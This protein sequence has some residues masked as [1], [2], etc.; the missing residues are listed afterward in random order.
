MRC[1]R[2]NK[3]NSALLERPITH[4]GLHNKNKNIYENSRSAFQA[5]I[6]YSLPIECDIQCSKDGKAVVFHDKMLDRLTNRTGSVNALN[7]NEITQIKLGRSEDYIQSFK[8]FLSQ[9]DGKVPLLIEIKDQSGELGPKLGG[10]MD[11]L[12]KSLLAYNGAYAII[13]F[14][15]YMIAYLRKAMPKA[16]LGLVTDDFLS[17]AWSYIPQDRAERLN[18]LAEIPDLDIDFVSH[19]WKDLQ[20]VEHLKIPKLCWT[21]KSPSDEIMARKIAD[22]ITF[23]QYM[24]LNQ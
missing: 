24:P 21:V 11:D 16:C 13:S 5:S 15:P 1:L 2:L 18:S 12:V 9:V 4:R 22:N 14:N 8:D 6:E 10:F 19:N 17:Q 7:L 20:R 23:E 3:I